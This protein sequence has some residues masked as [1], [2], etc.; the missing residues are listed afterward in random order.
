VHFI[1]FGLHPNDRRLDFDVGSWSFPSQRDPSRTGMQRQT[2]TS[3]VVH[4]TTGL[5]LLAPTRWVSRS[6]LEARLMSSFQRG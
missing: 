5:A 3:Y 6:L 2:G 1:T 4:R